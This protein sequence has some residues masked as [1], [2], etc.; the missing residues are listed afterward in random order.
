MSDSSLKAGEPSLTDA[1][2]AG[3][4]WSFT[5]QNDRMRNQ[6]TVEASLHSV[7][8]AIMINLQRRGGEIVHATIDFG[9]RLGPV[10]LCGDE[11]EITA[12]FDGQ[13]ATFPAHNLDER[14]GKVVALL[15]PEAFEQH[16]RRAR[17]VIVE[18][19]LDS[20]TLQY[21]FRAGGLDWSQADSPASVSG[22]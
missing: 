15:D 16:L 5:T 9:T 13:L 2:A 3:G 10:I 20:G 4:L 7:D 1:G 6:T 8:R 12:S 17:D 21:E 18:L 19:Q 14:P 11:C 22:L